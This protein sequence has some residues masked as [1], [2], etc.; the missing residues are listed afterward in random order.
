MSEDEI[1]K[2]KSS[3]A[4]AIIIIKTVVKLARTWSE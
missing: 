4:S 1:E 3:K 2:A